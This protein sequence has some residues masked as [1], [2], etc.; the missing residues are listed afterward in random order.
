[1]ATEQ[2][3]YVKFK[4]STF[5]EI[6]P[7][8]FHVV[9]FDGVEAISQ[10]FRFEVDLI[11]QDADID[12]QAL[13]GKAATL[14][15]SRDDTIRNIHG[16]ISI[17]EKGEETQFD[18]YSYK[19]VLVPRLWLMSLSSQNQ[20]HQE[21][22]VQQIV[23][24]EMTLGQYSG[25]M[26]KDEL[27]FRL[28][29]AYPVR[30]YTV[31]YKESDLNF[32]SRLLEHEGIFYAFDHSQAREQLVFCDD[33]SKLDPLVA[34]N[35]VS[36]VPPSGLATFAGQ[37]IHNFRLKQQQISKAFLLKDYNYRKP[38]I[39]L[40][41]E[42]DTDEL[43]L[44]AEPDSGSDD[45]AYGRVSNYGDH[46][47]DFAEAGQ[48]AKVR[49]QA[50]LCQ[51]QSCRGSSDA[52]LFAAGKLMA[53]EDHYSAALNGQY[54][55]THIRHRGGQALPGVAAASSSG[56]AIA[57][58]NDFEAISAQVQY[59][60]PQRAV[61]PRLYGVLTAKVDGAIDGD[62]A[63]I[64]E[65]GRYKLVM[66]FDVSGTGDGKASRWVRK[67]E[68]YG[69]QG[70]GM[71]FPL[72]K[73]SEVIWSCIDGDPDRPII[74][75]VVPNPLNKSV[76]TAKN[77][78]D[79]VIK[80]PSGIVMQM[81]DGKGAAPPPE[82][83]GT[84]QS[85][86]RIPEEAA[87][88]P[89]TSSH[90]MAG[91]DKTASLIQQQQYTNNGLSHN[92]PIPLTS[93]AAGSTTNISSYFSG[94]V[95]DSALL[96]SQSG[97]DAPLD[98]TG[99][100]VSLQG[101]LTWPTAP[102]DYIVAIKAAMPGVV[103]QELPIGPGGAMVRTGDLVPGIVEEIKYFRFSVVGLHF[104]SSAD[105]AAEVDQD[106]T[107]QASVGGGTGTITY[108]PGA[109]TTLPSGLTLNSSG[110]LTG[111]PDTAGTYTVT[112]T[113]TDSSD[114][115]KTVDQNFTLIVKEDV[116][117]VTSIDTDDNDTTSEDE[118]Q[119]SYSIYLPGYRMNKADSP[120]LQNS[121][122][123]IG[124]YYADEQT[125]FGDNVYYRKRDN[126]TIVPPEECT[127]FEQ[128]SNG[129]VN[130]QHRIMD[131]LNATKEFYGL[132]LSTTS[133]SGFFEGNKPERFGLMEYTDGAKLMIH[134]NGCFDLAAGTSVTYDSL[135]AD[136]SLISVVLGQ[137]HY[138]SG[139]NDAQLIKSER[140]HKYAT[141][142]TVTNWEHVTAY[143]Y[144]WGLVSS[145]FGGATYDFSISTKFD[146]TLG[147]SAEIFVGL[148][149]SVTLAASS[150]VKVGFEYEHG[151]S[152]AMSSV[153]GNSFSYADGDN[154]ILGSKIILQYAA[155]PTKKASDKVLTAGI[156]AASAV[157]GA[158]AIAGLATKKVGEELA[159]ALQAEG[160]IAEAVGLA[161][162]IYG[163]TQYLK[164][165][166]ADK[167]AKAAK[168]PRIEIDA[169]SITLTAG[170]A[171]IKLN[172]TGEIQI[173]GTEVKIDAKT[174]VDLLTLTGSM[175]IG[176][177]SSVLTHDTKT[178]VFGKKLSVVG[179]GPELIASTGKKT[180]IQGA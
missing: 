64:D 29:Q 7:D 168:T 71:N 149:S 176:P 25:G 74:T 170:L 143:N 2:R 66:P 72:L 5:D 160:A 69:G 52:M 116:A 144:N 126:G 136:D 100:A 55:I 127:S 138:E 137:N 141:L 151:T 61:K 95:A 123:R 173:E 157:I 154:H 85:Q 171:S 107:Y 81:R 12:L 33:N 169:T 99:A 56:Q 59:R 111:K 35:S 13:V 118:T 39:N 41:G 96:V 3:V 20:I 150:D 105:T 113:A 120:A 11:S 133:S 114:P 130:G 145:V 9:A 125:L 108:T 45:L 28:G 23:E 167:L 88:K 70:T 36:Y 178:S 179:M 121:Y 172:S 57:Y 93:T 91:K 37:A 177:A 117:F 31:Q 163:G 79:N 159:V 119:K 63:Q 174:K 158:T 175:K 134:Q 92:D 155:D 1:M 94:F 78:T 103:E 26:L 98:P 156:V 27:E 15:I 14:E 84:E 162:T 21:Q 18:T 54:L 153:A 67:A 77:S 60:P 132:D 83:E 10:P 50:Q 73:G 109:G 32:I 166:A 129:G 48:L 65:E 24:Q 38:D 128:A 86:T 8:L 58:Q 76:V 43:R 40:Q 124:S 19:A 90:Y 148:K 42:A 139:A 82:Q 62:R 97:S 89:V 165:E 4:S 131:V 16:V 22:T 161:T 34:Q 102:G 75:G 180:I 106:Y 110:S 46:F 104:T 147:I 122:S 115:V 87:A 142:W 6:G 30:E 140:F 80:T 164:A 112:I 101:V 53:M 135:G 146:F 51:Q 49:A 68:S 44:T 47:K 17:M 152:N